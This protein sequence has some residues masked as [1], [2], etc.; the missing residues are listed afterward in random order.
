MLAQLSEEKDLQPVFQDLFD[1]EGAEIYLK[2]ASDYVKLD[3]AVSYY[4]VLESALRK[5]EMAIGYRIASQ[6]QDASRMYGVKV[7][8]DKAQSIAY[9][10]SDKIIVL[11]ES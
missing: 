8:P 11:A 2:P 7:N 5:G 9:Q 4:T 3:T 6:S 1:P 10:A